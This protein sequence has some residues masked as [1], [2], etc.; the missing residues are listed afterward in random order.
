M[1]R[2]I[3]ARCG[4]L[5]ESLEFIDCKGIDVLDNIVESNINDADTMKQRISNDKRVNE[6]GRKLVELCIANNVLI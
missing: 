4:N 1:E 6:Y 2:D 3:N 5:I